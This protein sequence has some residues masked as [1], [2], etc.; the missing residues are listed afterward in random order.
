MRSVGILGVSR[1]RR[2]YRPG[3][4]DDGPPRAPPVQQVS[5]PFDPRAAGGLYAARFL[6]AVVRR[7]EQPETLR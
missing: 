5:L 7:P 4:D 1:G 2:R 3:P 6:S